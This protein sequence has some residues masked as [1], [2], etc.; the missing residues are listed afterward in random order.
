MGSVLN[1]GELQC[2][3]HQTH[4][5]R[6]WARPNRSRP[7]QT[8]HRRWGAIAPFH[9]PARACSRSPLTK[10]RPLRNPVIRGK[11]CPPAPNNQG[12]SPIVPHR[13]NLSRK[14]PKG[15]TGTK[16]QIGGPNSQDRRVPKGP[17]RPHPPPENEGY[18]QYNINQAMPDGLPLP[19]P[20]PFLYLPK[21]QRRPS[22]RAHLEGGVHQVGDTRQAIISL[23]SGF[24]AHF[25]R[26]W[27]GPSRP[28]VP[29]SP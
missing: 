18:S 28:S 10:G 23:P 11:A 2:S 29:V 17:G 14:N 20:L 21:G 13:G 24:P 6:K 26:P 16:G 15:H 1:P 3:N 25:S 19:H 8:R 22:P 9:P 12:S 5:D 4:P 27:D 7:C